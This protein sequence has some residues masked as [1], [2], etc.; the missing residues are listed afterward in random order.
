ME[1]SISVGR[2]VFL[3]TTLIIVGS[4]ACGSD[5]EPDPEVLALSTQVSELST[6][7]AVDSENLSPTAV[8]IETATPS[9]TNTHVVPE[10]TP[11]P[12]PTATSTHTPMPTST[13]THTPT[14][15]PT[16]THTPT[17]IPTPTHTPTPIPTPTH[18]PTPIPTPTH[19]P[20]PIPTILELKHYIIDGINN[21]RQKLGLD[22]VVLGDNPS[23]QKQAEDAMEHCIVSLWSSDGLDATTRHALA[24][25]ASYILERIRGYNRCDGAKDHVEID[26]HNEMDEMLE[27]LLTEPENGRSDYLENPR[28]KSISIGLAW[29]QFGM[30]KVLQFE[31]DAFADN[32]QVR[33]EENRII[34]SGQAK[35]TEITKENLSISI[36]YLPPAANLSRL[37]RYESDCNSDK[38]VAFVRPIADEGY[39]WIRD[40]ELKLV[41]D[42]TFPI[43]RP[44]GSVLPPPS[45]FKFTLPSLGEFETIPYI[46]ASNFSVN[47]R[48]ISIV[49]NIQKVLRE[50]GNGIYIIQLGYEDPDAEYHP[51]EI[52]LF[53]NTQKPPGW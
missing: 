42:C 8:I 47:R 27:K 40:S 6:Q 34:I 26:H 1:K 36:G 49:A 7:V 37:Q 44:A 21:E 38:L 5:P 39:E 35:S 9:V 17:P 14:P 50:H 23:A 15:I 28:V 10:S 30:W 16:P 29:N 31:Y 32:I 46:D 48:M 12:A 24:G 45:Q 13:P 19:T 33:L 51:V 3:L 43:D 25:E 22:A 4:F 52:P 41:S 2:I 20:T 53:Y 18:T 11:I